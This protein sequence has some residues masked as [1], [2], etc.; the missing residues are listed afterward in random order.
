MEKKGNTLNAIEADILT[1][2]ELAASSASS[3]L[4]SAAKPDGMR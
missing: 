1:A 2:D 4:P 3:P